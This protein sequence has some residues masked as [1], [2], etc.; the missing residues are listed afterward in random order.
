MIFLGFFVATLC[1]LGVAR[2]LGLTAGAALAAL[3]V[4]LFLLGGVLLD[5]WRWLRRLGQNGR[6]GRP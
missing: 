6:A 2:F 5:L 3:C 1:L 4:P